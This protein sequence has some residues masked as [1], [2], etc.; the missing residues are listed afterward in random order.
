MV[1]IAG[2]S[3]GIGRH[4]ALSFAKSGYDLAI[5]ARSGDDLRD[6][7]TRIEG[8]DRLCLHE[9]VDLTNESQIAQ[10]TRAIMATGRRVH[11]IVNCVG[12]VALGTSCMAEAVMDR[13][14]RVNFRALFSLVRCAVPL[15][16]Q[17]GGY[18]FDLSSIG[19]R[20]AFAGFGAYNATKFAGVGF[21]E[22]LAQELAER[23]IKVVSLCPSWVDSTM[24]YKV[25]P[26][27]QSSEL[28]RKEDIYRTI[29]WVMSLSQSSFVTHVDILCKSDLTNTNQKEV[30]S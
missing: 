5:C 21:M 4:L 12:T 18:I 29:C 26:R 8:C 27:L 10:F 11:V 19:G 14:Y 1:L 20:S 3:R 25:Q 17:A 15:L 7:A 13:L 23:N 30:L 2:A 16:E 22:A 28:I 9:S 24:A 6:L